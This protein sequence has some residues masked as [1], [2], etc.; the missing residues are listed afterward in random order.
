MRGNLFP[1]WTATIFVVLVASSCSS[2]SDH[3]DAAISVLERL[4]DR[5]GRVDTTS[6]TVSITEDI[7]RGELGRMQRNRQSDVYMAGASTMHVY[8]VGDSGR[9]GLWYDG[10]TIT[11]YSFSRNVY[12]TAPAPPTTI[13]TIDSLHRAFGV[14]FPAAD[15]FYPSLVQDVREHNSTIRYVGRAVINGEPCDH[16]MAK[17]TDGTK[18]LWVSQTTSL[19]VRLLISAS[20]GSR[21]EA[22]LSNWRTDA[23]L[24]PSIFIFTIPDGAK[25]IPIKTL[26]EGA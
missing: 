6:F 13:E 4:V 10:T 8:A 3:D 19:P 2:G 9:M 21:Y 22:T 11:V 5:M 15:F 25:Q 26:W 23:D 1:V 16:L 24:P 12:S 14:D 20:D 7:D 18:Q 17:G